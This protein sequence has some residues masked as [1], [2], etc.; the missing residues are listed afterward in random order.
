MRIFNTSG[1]NNPEKHYTLLR[2]ALVEQGIQ[3]VREDRYFTIWAP[4]QTGK[5]T[6]FLLLKAQLE[7]QGYQVIKINVE[8]LA[9]ANLETLVDRFRKEF[10]GM[11]LE[12]PVINNF[13]DLT[14]FIA[15]SPRTWHSSTSCSLQSRTCTALRS[16]RCC[17]SHARILQ[18][19]SLRDWG[20]EREYCRSTG[21]GQ[22]RRL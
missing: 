3:M 12:L 9:D 8:D 6:Y 18:M 7:Q 14:N 5:S 15:R 21:M 16:I 11:Q 20:S 1:P 10:A 2:A 13:G 22:S 4:R 17:A 19:H